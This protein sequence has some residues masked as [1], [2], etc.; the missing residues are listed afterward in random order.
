V[1]NEKGL[2]FF[3][4]RTKRESSLYNLNVLDCDTWHNTNIPC[5]IFG[6]GQNEPKIIFK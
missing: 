1:A 3:I 6:F 4:L 5:G 2:N